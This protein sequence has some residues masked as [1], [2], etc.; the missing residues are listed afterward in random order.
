[1]NATNITIKDIRKNEVERDLAKAGLSVNSL[2]DLEARCRAA[3]LIGHSD[4]LEICRRADWYKNC[5]LR[6]QI[7]LDQAARKAELEAKAAASKTKAPLTTG[8]KILIGV[9]I[10]AIVL[11]I[12]GTVWW[13]ISKKKADAAFSEQ[14]DSDTEDRCNRIFAKRGLA[15]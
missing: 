2:I 7:A 12:G 11:I 1:M 13:L 3:G 10:A 6:Q 9:G 8:Q 5:D 14:F 4:G 15:I